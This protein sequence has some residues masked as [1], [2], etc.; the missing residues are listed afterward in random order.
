MEFRAARPA[1]RRAIEAFLRREDPED[2]VLEWMDRLLSKG[3]FYLVVEGRT[4]AGLVHGSLAP[5]G[6]AWISAE[7]IGEKYRGEGRI[8]KLNAFALATPQLRRAQA[9]RMLITHDNASS[10]RA[11]TNGGFAAVSTLSFMDWQERSKRQRAL[12]KP[13]GFVKASAREFLR[14]ARGSRVLREQRGLAYMSFNG[15][16]AVNGESV[17][18][19]RPWLFRSATQGPIMACLFPDVR[20]RWM[21]VQ[22]FRANAAIAARLID[23]AREQSADSLTAILPAS[24]R[25]RRSF[26]AAG[27]SNSDWASRVFI[28]EKRRPAGGWAATSSRAA[29]APKT[30]RR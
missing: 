28:F 7:R 17:R 13:S 4:M 23:F 8:N 10:I 26:A 5:D 19:S 2:Y 18:A 11:A 6:S 30:Q 3:T 21:A 14:S 12:R 24:A 20:E 9:A 29:A 22:P 16:F 27:F 15:A 25:A 1:D